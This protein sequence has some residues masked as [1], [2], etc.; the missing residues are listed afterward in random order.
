MARSS[1]RIDPVS[2]NQGYQYHLEVPA[3]LAFDACRQLLLETVTIRALDLVHV[4]SIPV[5]PDNAVEQQPILRARALHCIF[6]AL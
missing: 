5:D 1:V 2:A 3:R 4:I 6:E